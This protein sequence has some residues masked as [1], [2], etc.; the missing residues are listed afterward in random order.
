MKKRFEK[1]T[2]ELQEILNEAGRK[3]ALEQYLKD[4]RESEGELNLKDYLNETLS[5][6]G[7]ELSD[8]V[9]NS[10]FDKSYVYCI[11]NGNRKNPDKM[12]LV[13]ICIASHMTLQETQRALEIAGKGVLYPRN[14]V[15]A[16]IIYNINK[17]N[18]SVMDINEQLY[19]HGLPIIE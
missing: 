2:K 6:K 15:D 12:K 14:P 9:K 11:F 17:E 10:G 7:M 13:G 18:W 5:K 16:I 1:S 4:V 8:V 3:T 19:E